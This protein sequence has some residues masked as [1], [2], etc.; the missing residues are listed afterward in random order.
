[1][2]EPLRILILEDNPADAEL[3]QFEIEEAGI[4]FSAKLVVEGKDYIRALEEFSPDVILSD[5]DLPT[6]NGSQALTEANKRCPEIPFILVTGA[7]TEDRAIEI[8]TQG[9][10]DYVLKSRL[11]QRLVPA[12]QRAI[13]EAAELKARRKAEVELLEAHRTLEK[14]VKLRTAELEKEMAVRR[15]MEDALRE[16]EAR[17]RHLV[18]YAPSGI[19]EIEFST[20][21]FLDV[22]D[23]MCQI[24]GYTR[25]ELLSM[26]AFDILDT[27]GIALFASRMDTG[28]SG[29][30]LPETVEYQVQTRYGRPIWALL[31]ATYHRREGR[32]IGATVVAHDITARRLAEDALR[33][34]EERLRVAH[35]LSLDAFTILGAV[36]NESNAIIDF[37]WEYVNPEAGRILRH[38]PEELVGR[39]LLEVL[40]GNK[41]NSD[42]FARYVRVVE[43]GE[44]HDYELQYRSEGIDGWFRNMTVKLGDGIAV[45][46]KDI[47]ERKKIDE[48]LKE[49]EEKCRYLVEHAP[50]MY[51]IDF[52][53]MKFKAINDVACRM[54]GYTE[55]ELLKMSPLDILDNDSQLIMLERIRKV[56][57]GEPLEEKVE[58]KGRGKD[59]REI[60]GI[61]HNSFIYENGKIV[62]AFVIVYDIAARYA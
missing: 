26:T 16:S 43:T 60:H 31:N 30:Q 39:R 27:E 33:K 21:R 55:A 51:E 19:Y 22:N 34:S 50:A 41:T 1:M 20:G 15:E 57:A 14:R 59:G 10:K 6:Y 7:V 36:R 8:L 11:Q 29:G 35:E 2:A 23:A 40:P 38:S 53:T 42:L 37:C 61:L 32:I 49:S 56:Q 28:Q 18:Q 48:A 58:Y 4:E 62:G 5:Y 47:T 46:F 13:A 17:Y 24:L 12:I 52:V 54:L 45:Y 25:E 9:A 3:T 44:P